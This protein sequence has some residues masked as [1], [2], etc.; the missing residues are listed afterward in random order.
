MAWSFSPSSRALLSTTFFVWASNKLYLLIYLYW[1][2]T[3]SIRIHVRIR[4]H[5]TVHSSIGKRIINLK[6]TRFVGG[7]TWKSGFNVRSVHCFFDSINLIKS[8]SFRTF[9]GGS[10]AFIITSNCLRVTLDDHWLEGWYLFFIIILV[11]V[12][13]WRVYTVHNFAHVLGCVVPL[14]FLRW[15]NCWVC[16]LLFQVWFNHWL[17]YAFFIT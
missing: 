4:F 10:L 13:T 12:C 5:S 3:N 11:D 17:V 6:L 2:E 16:R 8:R 7:W 14:A 15:L 1:S 9:L